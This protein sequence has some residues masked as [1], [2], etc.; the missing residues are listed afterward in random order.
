MSRDP[1]TTDATGGRKTPVKIIAGGETGASTGSETTDVEIPV[2]LVDEG[3]L[4]L[5]AQAI[6]SSSTVDAVLSVQ[7]SW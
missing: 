4:T 5:E 1:L 3:I 6:R 2:D 7:E